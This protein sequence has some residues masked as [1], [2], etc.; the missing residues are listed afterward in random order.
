MLA[1]HIWPVKLTDMKWPMKR[2]LFIASFF[3]MLSVAA[4]DANP[5]RSGSTGLIKSPA[6]DTL[7]SGNICIG[8]WC[9]TSGAKGNTNV[10]IPLALTM[11]LG[12]FWEIYGSYPNILLNNDEESAGPD[13]TAI[14]GMK[15]RL[16]LQRS[17]PKKSAID[18]F[19]RRHVSPDRRVDGISDIGARIIYSLR[20]DTYGLHFYGGYIINEDPKVIPAK[21]TL[22][23][24]KNELL[25]G[26][27]TEYFLGQRAKATFEL[28]ATTSREKGD[29]FGAEALIGYQYYLSPHLTFNVASGGSLLGDGA[30]WRFIFGF[31]SCQGIGTYIKPVPQLVKEREA[32]QVDK[33]RPSKVVPLSPLMVKSPQP[34]PV[35]KMEV[36]LDPDQEEIIVK[37]YG[38]VSVSPQLAAAPVVLPRSINLEVP[39]VP[40]QQTQPSEEK[41]QSDIE[42]KALEYTLARMSGTTP[43]FGVTYQDDPVSKSGGKALKS[44]TAM[45]V[46]RKFRFPDIIFDF[47]TTSLS[48]DVQK[49]LAEV[50]EIIRNDK[51]WRYVRIDGH[52]DNIGSVRYN[53]ELSLRRAIAVANHLITREGLD[54]TRV[55]VKGMGK[56]KPIADNTSTEGRAKNRRFEV[57]FLVDK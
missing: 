20:K 8:T 39:G 25:L 34:T 3:I 18:I 9:D 13:G 44:P 35:S 37:L 33:I 42:G 41:V 6:A 17:D 12:T 38:Q 1:M 11:G 15:F 21:S 57:L 55:F 22:P 7:D 30:T 40:G 32:K 36:P 49:S 19:A 16:G 26:S 14:I 47:G 4:A 43:L 5:N 51:K 56:S 23:G 28:N 45:M 2:P 50:A 46:Y 24:F 52:S 10:L 53:M 31:S 29:S 27:A 48:D 54:P